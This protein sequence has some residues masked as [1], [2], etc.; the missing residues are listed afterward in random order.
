MQEVM[1]GTSG[2]AP[3]SRSMFTR[4]IAEIEI[5]GLYCHDERH[6]IKP[7]LGQ[8][9]CGR[10]GC[11]KKVSLARK[12]G[13]PWLPYFDV[14]L[15]GTR[16]PHVMMVVTQMYCPKC[17]Q[18]HSETRLG[19]FCSRA[20]YSYARRRRDGSSEPIKVKPSL[21]ASDDDYLRCNICREAV[22]KLE[23]RDHKRA[24]TPEQVAAA[25]A[26]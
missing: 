5:H 13:E 16:M 14:V 9:S 24:H 23:L 17:K 20:C 19:P 26:P 25:M 3:A 8:T 22:D 7:R 11:R 18:P 21:A 1:I 4:H 12:R 6:E 2:S 10:P 15:N